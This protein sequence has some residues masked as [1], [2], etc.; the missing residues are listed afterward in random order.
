MTHRKMEQRWRA[1]FFFSAPSA[2]RLGKVFLDVDS[3][4]APKHEVCA[5]WRGESLHRR[6]R[7]F[8]NSRTSQGFVILRTLNSRF[9][10]G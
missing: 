6:D 5:A 7:W 3:K 8:N 10:F 9:N 4:R 1:L 2:F